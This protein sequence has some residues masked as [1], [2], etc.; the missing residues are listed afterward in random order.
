MLRNKQTKKV[1]IPKILLIGLGRFGKHHFRVLKELE[2]AHLIEFA[3]VVIL[4]KEQRKKAE[5]EFGIKTYTE[6]TPSMLKNVDAVDIVTPPETHFAIIKKCL[7]YTNVF[8]EKPLATTASDAKKLELLALKHKRV[9]TT[10]HILRFHPVTE[11][12]KEI[13]AKKTMP[14]KITGEFINPTALD[15]GREPS[16][17]FLH[18]FDVVDMLWGKDPDIVSSRRDGRVSIVDIRYAKYH[19]ARFVLGCKGDEKKRTLKF[20]YPEHTI[21]ADFVLNTITYK[22]GEVSKTYQCQ[23]EQELLHKELSEFVAT[24]LGSKNKVDPAT[25]SRIVSIAE[26]SIS[27]EKAFPSIAIIGG[28]IFGTSIAA[29]LGK[30]CSVTIFEK[31]ADLMQEGTYVNCFRHHSGYHYPRSS[32]TVVDIQ[33]SRKDFEKIYK[34]GIVST[35]PTYY[36]VAKNDSHTSTNEFIAFCK[37]HNLPYEKEALPPNLLSKKEISLCVKVPEPGYNYEK[38]TKIVK[39]RLDKE[40]NIKILCNSLITSLSLNKDGTK[41]V[42]YLKNSKIKTEKKFDFIINATYANINRVV[43]WLSFEQCPIRVDLAEVVV[44]KLNIDP[45]SITVID[46]PFATLIPTG[47]K[48][49]FTLYHVTESILDRYVPKDGF[50]KKTKKAQS[51]QKAILRESLRFFPILKDAIITESRVVNRG[52]LANHEHDDKRVAD[53]ID[54]GFGCFSILSGKILSSVTIGKRVAEIIKNSL[55]N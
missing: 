24:L 10:G 22:K 35:Y 23:S 8:T 46:G 11:K 42:T 39:G 25:A 19:D 12:L 4:N 43:E 48:N 31:N 55:R 28:G 6:I 37:K 9:L 45:V 29:E 3:G 53:L 27:K 7:P 2:A 54:H 5:A 41:T 34:K 17:E 1:K 18:L 47:N 16:L 14:L 20:K 50:I 32:E 15:Q 49:E 38:L 36:G 40:P 30:F 52:V 51:N 26:R 44:I 13:V 21:D 33:N